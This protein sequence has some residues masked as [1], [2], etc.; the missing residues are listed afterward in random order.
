MCRTDKHCK[1]QR[2]RKRNKTKAAVSQAPGS[3][4]WQPASRPPGSGSLRVTCRPGTEP[5]LPGPYNNALLFISSALETRGRGGSDLLPRRDRL[6]G[7]TCSREGQT[8]T[9]NRRM[10][11]PCTNLREPHAP[12]SPRLFHVAPRPEMLEARP[13]EPLEVQGPPS[14]THKTPAPSGEGRPCCAGRT[15]LGGCSRPCR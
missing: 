11:S 2:S 8:L 10:R 7:R 14:L 13:G 5:G 12:G 9:I 1:I 4:S 15:R 3:R 6:P